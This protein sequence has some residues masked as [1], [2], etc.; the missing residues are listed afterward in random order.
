MLGN[1]FE[2]D[3]MNTEINKQSLVRIDFRATEIIILLYV[4]LIIIIII[5][6]SHYVASVKNFRN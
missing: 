4:D 6:V 5:I 3:H 1:K 2:G